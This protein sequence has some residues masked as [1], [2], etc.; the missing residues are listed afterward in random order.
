MNA[1]LL[2]GSVLK[3][4]GHLA[5]LG[6]ILTSNLDD[7]S[8]IIK[9]SKDKP[10]FYHVCHCMVVPSGPFHPLGLVLACAIKQKIREIII[11]HSIHQIIS[12]LTKTKGRILLATV[13]VDY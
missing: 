11:G 3:Y 2:H 4:T 1:S 6:H 7:T 5:H 10:I 12:F 8:D 9:I 13:D